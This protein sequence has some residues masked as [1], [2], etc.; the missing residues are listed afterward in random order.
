MLMSSVL[1]FL[2]YFFIVN[3]HQVWDLLFLVFLVLITTVYYLNYGF[4]FGRSLSFS[5]I[6]SLSKATHLMFI[7]E[8]L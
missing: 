5:D 8:S 7:E 3:E 4:R 6:M 2:I 1:K